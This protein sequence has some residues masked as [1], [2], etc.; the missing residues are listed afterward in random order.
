MIVLVKKPKS[1]ASVVIQRGCDLLFPPHLHIQGRSS[2]YQCDGRIGY[3]IMP[4]TLIDNAT[5]KCLNFWVVLSFQTQA[6]RGV[7]SGPEKG[8][9]KLGKKDPAL[10]NT[11]T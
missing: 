8:G 2:P 5:Q 7:I 9:H 3:D 4:N 10:P 1:E 6:K 11:L